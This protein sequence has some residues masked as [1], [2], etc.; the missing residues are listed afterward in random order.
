[1]PEAILAASRAAFGSRPVLT[2]AERRRAL[3]A[4]AAA[5]RVHADR[6]CAAVSQ[7]F[8]YRPAQEV[9]L[10]E[11]VPLL[12]EIAH[13]SAHVGRW[14][15]PRRVWPNWHSLLSRAM[16]VPQPKGVVGII[17]PWNYPLILSLSP[18]ANALAAGNHVILKP[19]EVAPA[20]AEALR[21]MLAEVFPE[22]YVAVVTGGPEVAAGLA[23]LSLDHLV[24]TGSGA[25]GRKVMA[26]AAANLVPVTLELGGKSPAILHGSFP[27]REAAERIVTAKLWNAGQ[28][29]VAPDYVL[30]PAA[31]LDGFVAACVAVL[32]ERLPSA[33]SPDYGAVLRGPERLAALVAEAEAGGARVVRP[34]AEAA[35]K[36]AP[37]LVV[38]PGEETRLMREEIF[39][40]VLP[41]MP[42][43]DVAAAVAFVNARERPLALYYFDR[44]RRRIDRLLRETWSGGVTVNDCIYHLPQLRLPFGGIGASGMGAYTGQ[45]GFAEFS[46]MKAV[47]VQD[48]LLGRV[49]GRLAKP[50][51]GRLSRGAARVLTGRA[52][53]GELQRFDPH[54]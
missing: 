5:V 1:M 30:V 10:I 48:R 16:I 34:V 45:R 37:V 11:I 26:A 19:S 53:R 14:M 52:P 24:F 7:D 41:I 17:A 32:R 22:T 42:V 38:G 2:A 12:D 33:G 51:Y 28:T 36:V 29:C 39:G 35:G 8:G 50:P 3:A 44:D 54:G 49:L 4:L 15:R 21:A 20:T 31:R 40:P 25:V 27:L 9:R 6:L 43:A 47:L 23:A 18:L 46:H 13:L